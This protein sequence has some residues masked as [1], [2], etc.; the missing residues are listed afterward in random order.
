MVVRASTLR[1]IDG[2]FAKAT[3]LRAGAMPIGPSFLFSDHRDY[4]VA[5]ARRLHLPTI[6]P[7]SEF[8]AAGGLMSYDR[9]M[10]ITHPSA[11]V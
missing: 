10:V 7:Q 4:L 11:A 2:A 9:N 3:E 8:T 1:E 5:F 6:Y